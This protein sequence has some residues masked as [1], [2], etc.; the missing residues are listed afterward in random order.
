M[1]PILT[2]ARA[3]LFVV[4]VLCLVAGG[5]G[6]GAGCDQGAETMLFRCYLALAAGE[7]LLDRSDGLSSGLHGDY[8]DASG[9]N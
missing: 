4:M 7:N 8:A 1:I 5:C 3:I 9:Q 2:F 6:L